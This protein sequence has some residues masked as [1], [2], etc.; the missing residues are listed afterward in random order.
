[1]EGGEKER[2][3]EGRREGERKKERK[4]KKKKEHYCLC[5]VKLFHALSISR[6]K[7]HDLIF[8]TSSEFSVWFLTP[9]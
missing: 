2:G 3:R 4:R 5:N 7:G 1:M 9:P 6:S 8:K